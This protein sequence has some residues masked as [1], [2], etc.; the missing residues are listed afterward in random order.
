M[1]DW[2]LQEMGRRDLSV[3]A[4]NQMKYILPIFMVANCA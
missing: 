4:E 1:N 2:E 3:Y